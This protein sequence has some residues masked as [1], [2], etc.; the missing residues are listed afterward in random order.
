[1]VLFTA[2]ATWEWD[3]AE[4]NQRTPTDRS[5]DL[6]QASMVYDSAGQRALLFA[7]FTSARHAR[8]VDGGNWA[9]RPIAAA[10]G[11]LLDHAV[12]S[13][14][15]PPQDRDARDQTTMLK[16]VLECDGGDWHQITL[17]LQP[18]PPHVPTRWRTMPTREV[19]VVWR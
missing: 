1:V 3:G 14:L 13:Q 9:V 15:G 19:C 16:S 18:L 2:G 12:A 10:P 5:A 8:G 17:D 11:P 6:G 7:G 4:W